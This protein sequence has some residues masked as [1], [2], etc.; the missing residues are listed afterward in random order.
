MLHKWLQLFLFTVA[1]DL[2]GKGDIIVTVK[3]KRRM[4]PGACRGEDPEANEKP[5]PHPKNTIS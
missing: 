5:D 1:I 2:C 4:D 3:S